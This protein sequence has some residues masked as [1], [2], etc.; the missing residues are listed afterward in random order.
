MQVFA[1]DRILRGIGRQGEIP[2]VK[3]LFKTTLGVAWPSMLESFLL[4]LVGM[5]DSMMVGSLGAYAITAVGLTTQPKFIA[6]AFFL[7][8]NV[9]VSAIVA[10]RRG[11]N[12]RDGANRVL[13]QA[14]VVTL[15]VTVLI[16]AAL[17]IFAEPII[18]IAGAEADT[19]PFATIYFRIIMIG[20][21][22]NTIPLVINAAQRGAGNTKISLRTN[23]TSNIVNIILN[24]LLIG[25]NFGFPKWGVAG[26]AIA[27]VIGG[28]AATVMALRSVWHPDNFLHLPHHFK[29]R[30]HKP[31]LQSLVG[32]SASTMTEQV[33]MR[34]G[35]LVF[36]IIIARLGTSA[37]AAHQINMHWLS[38]SFAFGEG[39]SIAS[40]ALVGKSL[41]EKRPDLAKLY[42]SVCQQIAVICSVVMA[43]FF[44][45]FSPYMF[46]LFTDD[47]TVL[48]YNRMLT[49]M[50]SIVVFVQIS[51]V[52]FMGCLRGSGDVKFTAMVSTICI[53]I[54]RPA[55][56]FLF[57]WTFGLGLFGAWLSLLT[58]QTIR[59]IL[60]YL[61][62]RGG[63]W[64]KFRL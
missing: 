5:I 62:F 24:Y 37:F 46:L 23:M 12:D 15:I 48:T 28:A 33:F 53:G 29:F 16:A 54:I 61:R 35:F 17:V 22:F 20:L 6:L 32:I 40:V 36:S 21:L 47:P 19:H 2:P 52:V 39:L 45:L 51:M 60:T 43:G 18:W 10:R 7:S 55:T 25:G 49:T 38:L 59:L 58:D 34:I 27:T 26:A 9:A 14:L 42:G 50:L 64:T 8:L 56:G 3:T 31:T 57:S 1:V 4:N 63:Q 11:E 44:T 41:G 13:V 30:F